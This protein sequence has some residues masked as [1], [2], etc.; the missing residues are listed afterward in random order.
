MTFL[1]YPIAGAVLVVGAL[2][3]LDAREL[4]IGLS[5]FSVGLALYLAARNLSAWVMGRDAW[6]WAYGFARLGYAIAVGLIAEALLRAPSPPPWAWRTIAYQIG[7][8]LGAVGLLGV[9]LHHRR[10]RTA[11]SPRG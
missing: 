5:A 10:R 2:A 1:V 3:G 11:P 8:V 4:I 7:L 9:V 6:G